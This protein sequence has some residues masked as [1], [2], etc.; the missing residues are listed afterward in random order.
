M[1]SA[2]Q[3]LAALEEYWRSRASGHRMPTMVDLTIA[4]LGPWHDNIAWIDLNDVGD[5]TFRLCGPNLSLRLGIDVTGCRVV[6]LSDD[7]V[8]T[9]LSCIG[10]VRETR[11][12]VRDVRDRMAHGVLT[13]FLDLSLPLVDENGASMQSLL[14]ASY[15]RV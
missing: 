3:N 1:D 4:D 15:P 7:L 2:C 14:F 12:P 5:G 9:F 11:A 13:S 10:R 6:A 8:A